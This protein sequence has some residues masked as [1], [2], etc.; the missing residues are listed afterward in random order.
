[1]KEIKWALYTLYV[2]AYTSLIWAC[3]IWNGIRAGVNDTPF[4]AMAATVLSAFNIILVVSYIKDHWN[5][6]E[7]KENKG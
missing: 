2:M 6:P 7:M 4:G 5:D 3:V 1:M